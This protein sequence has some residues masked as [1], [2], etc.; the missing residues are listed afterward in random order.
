MLKKIQRR[1]A[2]LSTQCLDSLPSF[3]SRI[4]QN[5]GVTSLQQLDLKLSQLE[6]SNKIKGLD[7][8][9]ALLS[10]ALVK[11]EKI[12]IVG[13]F[14]CDGATSTALAMLVLKHLVCVLKG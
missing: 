10:E 5:R 11:Q 1:S 8:A 3:I 12:L 13:D 7:K 6:N 9:V 14:D 4:Y 2:D